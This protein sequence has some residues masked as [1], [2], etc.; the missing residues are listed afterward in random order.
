M[1]R[2]L[3]STR[4]VNACKPAER[5]RC[6]TEQSPISNNDSA[7]SAKTSCGPPNGASASLALLLPFFWTIVA[8]PARSGASLLTASVW[9]GSFIL[10][11]ARRLFLFELCPPSLATAR[12]HPLYGPSVPMTPSL[13]DSEP[14][15]LLQTISDAHNTK[16]VFLIAF[17][18]LIWHHISTS[19]LVLKFVWSHPFRLHATLF[20]SV[21]YIALISFIVR[22][23]SLFQYSPS[24]SV[25]RSSALA[26]GFFSL[27]L[28]GLCDVMLVIRVWA[29]YECRRITLLFLLLGLVGSS[30][31]TLILGMRW[32]LTVQV[33]SLNSINTVGCILTSPR[34]AS[35][36]EIYLPTIVFNTILLIMVITKSWGY[37]QMDATTPITTLLIRDGVI[38]YF[39]I[40]VALLITGLG[41][42]IPRLRMISLQSGFSTA[43]LSMVCSQMQINLRGALTIN[44][45]CTSN[46]HR[47]YRCGCGEDEDS[48]DETLHS[49]IAFCVPTTP[50]SNL[51]QPRH[52]LPS[53]QRKYTI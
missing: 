25:C 28:I 2:R 45:I 30:V 12:L 49:E 11:I 33:Q 4:E 10:L 15:A 44:Y 22:F 46:H 24:V 27:L 18:S 26:T 39:L 41:G 35:L 8:D 1:A 20:L 47:F 14:L 23:L 38:S 29:I 16:L 6:S 7:L 21:R 50:F 37:H 40:L 43:I 36:W 31:S 5:P 32:Y 3:E 19:P 13:A 34:I 53:H 42:M 48:E 52:S 51:Y 17:T 9:V